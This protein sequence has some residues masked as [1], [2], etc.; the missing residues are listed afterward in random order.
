MYTVADLCIFIHGKVKA[1]CF[2]ITMATIYHDCKE[3]GKK[4]EEIKTKIDCAFCGGGGGK[5]F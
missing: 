1:R 5:E 3:G 2:E 4:H